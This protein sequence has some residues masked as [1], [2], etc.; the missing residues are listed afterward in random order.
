MSSSGASFDL[1]TVFHA[2]ATAIPNNRV[3]IWRDLDPTYAQMDARID[4]IAHYSTSLGLGCHTERDQLRGHQS[5]QDHMGLYLRNGNEYLEAMV[6]GYRARVAPFNVNYRYV[7][8]ELLYLLTDSRP[9][10]WCTARS[11]PR[12]SP[13]SATGCPS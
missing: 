12:T 5:G 6:A 4:G 7:E 3:L 2:V 11:S 10:R 13:P 1:S 8:E 9:G